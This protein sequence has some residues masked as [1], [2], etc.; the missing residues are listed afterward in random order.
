MGRRDSAP[1]LPGISP[2]RG[3]QMARRLSPIANVAERVG[4]RSANLPL[5][6]MAGRPEGAP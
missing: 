3:D 1:A 4:G 6:G 2:I 5:V